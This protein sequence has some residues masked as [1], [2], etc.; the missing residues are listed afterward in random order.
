M[1]LANRPRVA[2]LEPIVGIFTLKAVFNLLTEKSV[3]VADA[4][5]VKRDAAVGGRVK[6]AGGKSAKSAVA[7]GGVAHSLK[8]IG[9]GAVALHQLNKA[10]KQACVEQVGVNH[11][12]DKKFCR[13]IGCTLALLRLVPVF[14][15]LTDSRI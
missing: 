2:P 13:Q 8:Y 12:A 11:S 6:I 4:V 15:N 9:V 3:A 7:K 14:C 10:V 1:L 5:A